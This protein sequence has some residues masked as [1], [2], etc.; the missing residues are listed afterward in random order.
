VRLVTPETVRALI[1][2][3][4]KQKGTK[5][6]LP[7]L[8]GEWFDV[9]EP[10]LVQSKEDYI[11]VTRLGRKTRLS[12]SQRETLWPLFQDVHEAIAAR[13]ETTNANMFGRVT[14]AIASATK[15]P[16]DFAVI[17]EAQ[18]LAAEGRFLAAFGGGR[19]NA[20]FFAGDLGQ[21]IF[22]TPFSWK[23]LG[24]D[25]RGRSYTLRVNYRTSHQIRTQADRLLPFAI[26]DVDGNEE[27]R[28]GTVS[29]FNGPSPTVRAFKSAEAEEKAI[30]AWIAER[31]RDGPRPEEIGVFVRSEAELNRARAAAKFAGVPTTALS[32]DGEAA[33]GHVAVSPMHLA[34]GLEFRAVA[35]M[36]CDDEILPQQERIETVAD[37]ADLEE[38]YNT[39]RHL[40]YVA[41]T[42]ARDRLIVSGVEPVSEFLADF[43][44]VVRD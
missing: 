36:A 9:I 1:A 30:G 3:A 19:P 44:E 7:F 11:K 10:W 23:S 4:T 14:E 18:D 25:I 8:I 39:E 40:L 35:V 16:Y 34:K 28:K 32:A 13:G 27:S 20:L 38:V 37:D 15:P 42:R 41:C 29:V 31:I 5:F 33:R 17:D 2:D 26:A 22:Q 21:R 24:L 12:V 6:S 43:G